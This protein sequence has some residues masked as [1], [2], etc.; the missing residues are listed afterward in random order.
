MKKTYLNFP[1][2]VFQIRS[3]TTTLR[4]TLY[5]PRLKEVPPP[6]K[7]ENVFRK[8]PHPVGWFNLIANSSAGLMGPLN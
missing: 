3:Y 6:K 8:V 7:L 2:I 5:H 4:Y 1:E